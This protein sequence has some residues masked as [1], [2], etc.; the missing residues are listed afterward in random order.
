[1]V[2]LTQMGWKEIK[3]NEIRKDFEINKEV[4]P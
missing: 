2:M 4:T 1:M 3:H